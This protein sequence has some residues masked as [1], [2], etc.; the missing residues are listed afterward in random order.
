[1]VATT[2]H[3]QEGAV[4]TAQVLEIDQAIVVQ[5]S[6]RLVQSEAAFQLRNAV[7]SHKEA[8]RVVLD[9]SELDALGGGGLGMVAFLQR[10]AEQNGIPLTILRPNP[11][12][13]RKLKEFELRGNCRFD[14]ERES[15]VMK[16]VGFPDRKH[17]VASNLAA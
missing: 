12:T 16:L 9:F 15:G 13:E 5:C 2:R 4:F 8:K 11:Q 14:I 17:W 1:M 10:W 3:R 7:Q 6:G